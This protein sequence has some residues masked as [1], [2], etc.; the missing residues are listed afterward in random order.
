MYF[1]IYHENYWADRYLAAIIKPE[2]ITEDFRGAQRVFTWM[3]KN[4]YDQ[5]KLETISKDDHTYVFNW[6]YIPSGI[7][8]GIEP[9]SEIKKLIKLKT[10]KTKEKITA[11]REFIKKI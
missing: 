7:M 9:N 1:K 11:M 5:T 10:K 3:S 8:D 2:L 6:G 4:L